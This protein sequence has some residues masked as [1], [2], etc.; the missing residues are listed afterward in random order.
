MVLAGGIEFDFGSEVGEHEDQF[1]ELPGTAAEVQAL[2]ELA[3]RLGLEVT[4][5][6]GAEATKQALLAALPEATFVHLATHG[7]FARESG[8]AVDSRSPAPSFLRLGHLTPSDRSTAQ[9]LFFESTRNPLVESG[10]ALAGAN[11][12]NPSSFEAT[13]ILTAEEWINF[14]LSRTELVTLSACDT[15]LGQEVTGQGVLGLRSAVMAAGSRSV[16]M[17]LWKVP[18]RATEQLMRLFYRNLWV[19]RMPK[20][21]AVLRAQHA[22]R[23]DVS[24]DFASPRSWA[25][26]ALVGEGW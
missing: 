26:W 14:D 11:V 18:D 22:R 7:F 9:A 12:R 13:G 3:T 6:Q 17:S 23:N 16:L 25:V 19:E 24:G 4:V 10:L 21:G 15:G 5:F 20:I 2:A 1:R 8:G